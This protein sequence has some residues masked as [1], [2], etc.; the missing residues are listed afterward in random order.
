MNTSKFHVMS[1][2][3]YV[4]AIETCHRTSPYESSYQEVI[5]QVLEAALSNKNIDVVISKDFRRKETETHCPNGYKL[6][7]TSSPDFI[8]A[9]NF[10]YN[11]RINDE[12]P[13]PI[14]H[15]LVEVKSPNAIRKN[16]ENNLVYKKKEQLET[17]L[18]H[19]NID[20]LIFTDGYT[21]VFF[22]ETLENPRIIELRDDKDEWKMINKNLKNGRVEY[23]IDG[24]IKPLE[25]EELHKYISE[26]CSVNF[27]HRSI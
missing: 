8:L 12:I 13:S 11:N 15:A 6:T 1:Y 27:V 22:Y 5:K 19:K 23:Y 24:D 25:W 17:Y 21:W 3:R 4:N 14:Y 9:E 16:K 2:E 7:G 18:K 26:F 20:K 10:V